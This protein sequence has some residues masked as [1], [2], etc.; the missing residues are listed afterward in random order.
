MRNGEDLTERDLTA[1]EE[2]IGYSFRDKSLLKTC[3]THKSYS[4]ARGG[5]NNERLE[6]LGD[7]VLELCV[8][9]N[10]YRNSSSDEGALTELRQ[11]YVSQT[12]LES[13]AERAGLKRFLRYSGGENNVGG[14]TASNL[15]EAVIGGVYLDGGLD[16]V[17]AFLARYLELTESE[18]Y[19]TLLQEYVQERTK[20]TPV[21]SSREEDGKYRCT[22]RALGK[23][24]QGTGDSK[25]AAETAAA[26]RLYQILTKECGN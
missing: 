15:F 8:T 25:K 2:A 7:A 3:F 26:Q 1:A 11:R 21:Y 23:E 16:E 19:K 24:A 10:L 5:E 14:K 20:K 18:N 6:F 13:A 22:V 12:A 4:N 17:R 9:E